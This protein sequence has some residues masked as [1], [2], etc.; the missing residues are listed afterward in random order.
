MTHLREHGLAFLVVAAILT[1]G[2]VF[3]QPEPPSETVTILFGRGTAISGDGRVALERTVTILRGDPSAVAEVSGHTWPGSD[4][5]AD[6]GLAGQRARLVADELA[7][8]GIAEDR[9]EVAPDGH[10][11][12]LA[13]GCDAAWS[14]RDCRLKHARAEVLITRGR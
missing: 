8:R 1:T 9:V 2:W 10:V 7:A 3:G 4:A 6:L 14:E 12:P 13:G 11:R 5:E